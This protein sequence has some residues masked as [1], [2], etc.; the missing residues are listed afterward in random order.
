M[1]VEFVELALE[2]GPEEIGDGSAGVVIAQ[3]RV[4][5]RCGHLI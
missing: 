3:A 1:Q 5:G 4:K 2:D